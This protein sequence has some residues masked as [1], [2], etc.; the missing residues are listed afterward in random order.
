MNYSAEI[1]AKVMSQYIGQK[2][3]TPTRTY[4]NKIGKL[5]LE[6]VKSN[7]VDGTLNEIDLGMVPD[8]MGVLLDNEAD[9][10]NYKYFN[11][12]ESKLILKPLSDIIDEHAIEVGKIHRY[13][14]CKHHTSLEVGRSFCRSLISG[15]TYYDYSL[16]NILE[17]IQ[18]LQ[19]QGYD[20]PHYLLNGQTLQQAGLA[21]YKKTKI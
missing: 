10:S 20:I 18:Y 8:F 12:N 11:P 21:V 6:G 16:P 3:T 5:D 4:E 14:D 15:D 7:Y 13:L 2:V 17:A 19:S 1:K 9:K